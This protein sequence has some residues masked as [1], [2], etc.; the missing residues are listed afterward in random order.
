M[1]KKT[2]RID[3]GSVLKLSA[4]AIAGL[5]TEALAT[6]EGDASTYIPISMY[7]ES[8]SGVRRGSKS[9]CG[10]TFSAIEIYIWDHDCKPQGTPPPIGAN[11]IIFDNRVGTPGTQGAGTGGNA[12]GSY[13]RDCPSGEKKTKHTQLSIVIVAS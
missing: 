2:E 10:T 8:T 11:G 6:R 1:S 4:A 3:R 5:V 7:C 13:A 12:Q 9:K